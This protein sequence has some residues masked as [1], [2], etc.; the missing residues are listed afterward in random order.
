MVFLLLSANALGGR[1]PVGPSTG[2]RDFPPQRWTLP[3]AAV[4]QRASLGFVGAA[5]GLRSLYFGGV[6]SSRDPFTY[7]YTIFSLQL[8]M[9]VRE[10]V[11]L[12]C[13]RDRFMRLSC[14]SHLVKKRVSDVKKKRGFQNSAAAC[15]A[16]SCFDNPV[17]FVYFISSIKKKLEDKQAMTIAKD[18][19]EYIAVQKAAIDRNPE[20]G[21]SHYN[22]AVGYMG[23]RMLEQAE[24]EL[25][26]AIEC[27]PGLAEAYVLLGGICMQRGDLDGCLRHN[28][29]A[30][31]V[32]PGFSEAYG[33]IG[34]VELQ[35]GNVDEAI[36][37]LERATFFNFRYIQAFTN[38]GNA[39]L[40][41]G[42]IDDAIEAAHK[43]LKLAPDFAPAHNNLAIAYLEKNEDALAVEHF[44]RAVALGYEVADPIRRE[45]EEK[46]VKLKR[47]GG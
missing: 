37:N 4:C 3:A 43:A 23:K 10:R 30:V 41:K 16:S 31:K 36:K 46:R 11:P 7:P 32:R 34:F 20:C 6:G 12:R 22:L 39:Y 1:S 47:A 42:R 14:F 9:R 26:E 27:S 40:M 44:D 24:K 5:P 28:H 33:N 29:Q 35:R 18:V 13:E 38:L 15:G 19:D 25:Y 45:I 21:N 2:R 17:R 8:L